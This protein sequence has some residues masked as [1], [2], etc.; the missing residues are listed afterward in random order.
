MSR[1]LKNQPSSAP[2]VLLAL[3]ALACILPPAPVH[4]AQPAAPPAIGPRLGDEAFFQMLDLDR[5][6]QAAVKTAVAKSDWT[7]ARH[8]LAE[9]M[10]TRPM[11]RWSF[12]PRL[13]GDRTSFSP[14]GAEDVLRHR[15]SGWQFGSS[16]DWSFNP[17]TR[18]GST[19][20]ANPEWTWGLNRHY[21]WMT[22]SAAWR[23]GGDEKFAA[24][25]VRQLQSWVHDSPVP[26]DRWANVPFSHWRTIEA[27]IRAGKVWPYVFFGFLNAKSF[28]DD[29]LTLMLKSYVE[30]AR[31]LE[32]FHTSGNWL[33]MEMNGLYHAGALFPEFKEAASW[34]A[35]ALERL[36]REIDIQVYPDG[37]QVE[38]T[39]HYH[40]VAL[41]NM[42]GPVELASQTGFTPPRDYLD[43]LERM[44]NYL[45]YSMQPQRRTPPLNDSEPDDVLQPMQLAA[46]LYPGRQDF[47]WAATDGRQGRLPERTSCE[48]PYAG[49]SFMRSGWGRDALWLCMDGGPYGA[50]HQH[51]DKLSVILTAYGKPLLVEAGSYDYDASEWRRYVLSSRAHNLVLI[52]GLEQNRARSPRS[53]YVVKQ[54]LAHVWESD[55]A[56]DHAAAAYDEGWGPGAQR[57]VRQTRHVW[58]LKSLGLYAVADELEPADTR[59]HTYEALFHLDADRVTTEG[60]RVATANAGPNLTLLAA[61]PD[62]V[63]IVKGQRNP[64]QGWLPDERRGGSGVRPIPTA[65]YSR[66]AA[67]KV[68]LLTVLAP[69]PAGR[70]CPLREVRL[71][72]TALVLGYADGHEENVALSWRRP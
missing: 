48:F 22:L 49:Q 23:A 39:P 4:A 58:F 28:D 13:V 35:D 69:T 8:A 33:T 43:R 52:D 24:E 12:S 53:S 68:T 54:P 51:A 20:P 37:V 55:A 1:L 18:P 6:D 7:A 42:L 34:R 3:L 61:G 62:A 14:N 59:E 17:T 45:L 41:D 40:G 10:R 11:P 56:M 44:F 29:A 32:K 27:G 64:V 36:G 30:H 67:G 72:G 63:R 15:L 50:G 21:A 71:R 57:L 25:F 38:L 66:R 31:F 5:A 16:I 19:Q 9:H 60:L 2:L 65:V 70:P 46:R 26:V 47:L